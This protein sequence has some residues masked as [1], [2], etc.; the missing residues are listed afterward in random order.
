MYISRIWGAKTPGRIEFS[1][2]VVVV[3]GV[4]TPFKF[5]DDRFRGFWLAEGQSLPFPIDPEGCPLQHSHYRVKC[6]HCNDIFTL[7]LLLQALKLANAWQ[8]N[9]K[10]KSTTN[11]Q[12]MSHQKNMGLYLWSFLGKFAYGGPLQIFS[13]VS[14]TGLHV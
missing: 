4:I 9:S 6:D 14:S 7:A 11:C 13:S 2:L 5:G 1:F 12:T 3:H 10:K 8:Q